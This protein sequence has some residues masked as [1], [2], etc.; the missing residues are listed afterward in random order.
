MR[1]A[2][3]KDK[4]SVNSYT[5]AFFVFINYSF[6]D[7]FLALYYSYNG[8][9]KVWRKGIIFTFE[10]ANSFSGRGNC[11]FQDVNSGYCAFGVVVGLFNLDHLNFWLLEEK[12]ET[13]PNLLS[14]RKHARPTI[15]CFMT[16]IGFE[17]VN[18]FKCSLNCAREL[19]KLQRRCCRE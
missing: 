10:T 4:L 18:L 16:I 3:W 6:V 7:L 14:L 11:C 19:H 5:F 8:R 12:K 1:T 13:K 2:K 17:Y 9:T 15:V